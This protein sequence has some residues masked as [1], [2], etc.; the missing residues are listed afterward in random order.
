[1]IHLCDIVHFQMRS[2]ASCD[3]SWISSWVDLS[4]SSQSHLRPAIEKWHSLARTRRKK[5]PKRQLPKFLSHPMP[6]KKIPSHLFCSFFW[7]FIFKLNFEKKKNEIKWQ[8]KVI[9]RVPSGRSYT[10]KH[11]GNNHYLFL[12]LLDGS[13]L[14]QNKIIFERKSSAF[15]AGSRKL[16]KTLFCFS[17]CLF[18]FPLLFSRRSKKLGSRFAGHPKCRRRRLSTGDRNQCYVCLY[19]RRVVF[20]WD[21]GCLILTRFFNIELFFRVFPFC[22]LFFKEI[23]KLRFKNERPEVFRWPF[24]PQCWRFFIRRI[25]SAFLKKKKKT[26][27][28]SFVVISTSCFLLVSLFEMLVAIQLGKQAR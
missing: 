6:E 20:V 18:G 25:V 15:V 27:C 9:G 19:V 5:K 13:C 14:K 24:V 17:F 12:F 2:C 11:V 26:V 21:L 4:T 10:S 7:F 3:S 8:T 23:K 1:M 28:G 16:Y 22:W